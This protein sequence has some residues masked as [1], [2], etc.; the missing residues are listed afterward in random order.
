MAKQRLINCDFMNDMTH[1]SNKGKLLYYTFFVNA[2]DKGFVGNG[3]ELIESLQGKTNESG[4]VNLSLLDNDFVSALHELLEQGLLYEFKSNHNNRVYLIRHWYYHNK[5]RQGLWTNYYKYLCMVEV[6]NNE[7]VL[8]EKPLKEKK[9]NEN[10]LNEI[11]TIPDNSL[12]Y[13]NDLTEPITTLEDFLKSKR[14]EKYSDLT[15]EQ[16]K[17][18][19]EIVNSISV[20]ED[21][22]PF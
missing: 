15:E 17:E 21:D 16:K 9:L 2:D 11:K 3:K 7:Y 5:L 18:W 8:K 20:D 1:I 10:K 19:E 14:V 12:I 4:E 13:D 22:L 6:V